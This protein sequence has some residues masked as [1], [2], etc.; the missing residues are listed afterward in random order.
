MVMALSV[1]EAITVGDSAI[2]SNLWHVRLQLCSFLHEF[3]N[4]QR[5]VA[6]RT[7]PSRTE[8]GNIHKDPGPPIVIHVGSGAIVGAF[9]QRDGV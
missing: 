6:R 1:F 7:A 5:V 2:L 3:R 8:E 9:E 4:S